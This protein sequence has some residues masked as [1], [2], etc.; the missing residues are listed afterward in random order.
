MYFLVFCFHNSFSKCRKLATSL[1]VFCHLSALSNDDVSL[2]FLCSPPRT[3]KQL[4]V[5]QRRLPTTPCWCL[6]TKEAVL[7]PGASRLSTRPAVAIRTMTAST[8]GGHVSRSWL[9]C[10]EEETTTCCKDG[11][12]SLCEWWIHVWKDQV[13]WMNEWMNWSIRQKVPC[14]SHPDIGGIWFSR[15]S[16][17]FFIFCQTSC[18]VAA[19]ICV[20]FFLFVLFLLFIRKFEYYLVRFYTSVKSVLSLLVFTIIFLVWGIGAELFFLTFVAAIYR[21]TEIQWHW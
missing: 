16:V 21:H 20:I 18:T 15:V 2:K 10:T 6:T 3:W 19:R 11:C 17:S 8:S 1:F 7:T 12:T 9:T 5:T 4:T 14:W 13:I